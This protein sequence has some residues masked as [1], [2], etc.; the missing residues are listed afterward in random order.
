[1]P[2]AVFDPPSLTLVTVTS[3]SAA[4]SSAGTL[5]TP[6]GIV[7]V[8]VLPVPATAVP[9]K[10][11]RYAPAGPTSTSTLPVP[12][13]RLVPV[14]TSEPVKPPVTVLGAIDAIDGPAATTS[15]RGVGGSST[16]PGGTAQAL[17]VPPS[18]L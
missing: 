7:M 6:D 18:G 5:I 2:V 16:L 3:V 10:S 15:G 14:M 9:T 8:C 4:V 11:F 13:W 1:M 17:D 12:V